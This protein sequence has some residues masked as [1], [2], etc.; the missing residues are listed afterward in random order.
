MLQEFQPGRDPFELGQGMGAEDDLGQEVVVLG[1][2]PLGDLEVLLEGRPRDRR[3][4][5]AGGED[6]GRSEGQAQGVSDQ[7]VVLFE[8]IFV[9]ADAQ[10]PEEIPE[11]FGALGVGFP[12]EDDVLV[13]EPGDIGEGRP[14]HRVDGHEAAAGKASVVV[15]DR[16]LHRSDIGNDA[17][18]GEARDDGLEGGDRVLQADRVD[19]EAGFERGDPVHLPDDRDRPQAFRFGGDGIVDANLVLGRELPDEPSP[20]V[21]GA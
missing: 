9:D 15:G 6:H 3:A 7:P 18:R 1:E 10:L 19:E 20:H 13:L 12:D 17:V 2:E 4:V 14:E 21:A 11:E 16:P 5:H 8:G